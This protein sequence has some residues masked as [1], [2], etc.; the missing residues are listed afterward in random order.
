VPYSKLSDLPDNVRKLPK[1]RQQQWLQVWNSAYKRC[2]SDNPGDSKKCETAAFAQANGVVLKSAAEPESEQK[3]DTFK[4]FLNRL[5]GLLKGTDELTPETFKSAVKSARGHVGG[6]ISRPKKAEAATFAYPFDV[7]YKDEPATASIP[8]QPMPLH[9][10][11]HKD[12]MPQLEKSDDR[13]DYRDAENAEKRCG[14]CRF[15]EEND[16]YEYSG[17]CLVEGMIDPNYVCNLFTAQV[18]GVDF[19]EVAD[20]CAMKAG[21]SEPQEGA[22]RLFVELQSFNEPPE[23]IPLLPSPGIYQH[24]KF[25]NVAI[26]TERNQRFV[27]GFKRKVYQ[28]RLPID[29]EHELKLG[30]AFG[31]IVDMR[32]NG[33]GSADARV[34][35]SDR[36]QKLFASDGSAPRFRYI[37]PEWYDEWPDP[38]DG[39]RHKDVVIGAALTTRPFFKERALRPLVASERG[40]SVPKDDVALGGD[41]TSTTEPTLI[42]VQ[43]PEVDS[44]KFYN[45]YHDAQGRMPTKVKIKAQKKHSEAEEDEKLTKRAKSQQFADDD[46]Q[47]VTEPEVDEEEDDEEE[48]DLESS[49]DGDEG[50]DEEEEEEQP[51]TAKAKSASEANQNQ[52][53]VVTLTASQFSELTEQAKKASEMQTQLDTLKQMAEEQNHVIQQYSEEIEAMKADQRRKRFTDMVSGRGGAEDG[54]RPWLGDPQKHVA[55]LET[56]AVNFGEDSDE[57]KTYTE[58]QKAISEQAKVA[59]LFNEV[60]SGSNGTDSTSA[61]ARMK[62]RAK[63]FME[64]DPKLTKEQAMDK[65]MA[66]EPRL[67]NEYLS[68]L[69]KR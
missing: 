56:L 11:H 54:A 47:V 65:V 59:N 31:W 38:V 10:Y 16:D 40:L 37:S 2:Q 44:K 27:D 25:N 43:L 69:S 35:W 58:M 42:F 26:T 13:V 33:D 62:A 7:D 52:G 61:M 50:E 19:K 28:E 6:K 64:A 30:G 66:E 39:T 1:K 63:T 15:F 9:I 57:L 32:L 53:Q 12:D 67:Y 51:V 68:E 3:P 14:V 24:P 41:S 5:Y 4:L 34:E 8:H 48:D 29:C 22:V 18:R 60:G 20:L 46:D 36:G 45:P 21:E 55:M 23:W 17:C 49:A